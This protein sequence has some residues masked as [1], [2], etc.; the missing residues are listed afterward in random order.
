MTV[1][2]WVPYGSTNVPMET[3]VECPDCLEKGIC[4]KCGQESIVIAKGPRTAKNGESI[5]LW[6]VRDRSVCLSCQWEENDGG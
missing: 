1:V 4:P 6:R 2:D 5:P 3:G